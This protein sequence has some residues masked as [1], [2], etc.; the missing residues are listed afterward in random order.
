MKKVLK[1][2]T[3]SFFHAF[4]GIYWAFTTQPNFIIHGIL[5]FLA[6]SLGLYF[7]ISR[8]EM[9]IIIFTII[10]GFTVE[11]INTSIESITDMVTAERRTEAKIAKDVSAGMML[12]TAIGAVII[13]WIIFGPYIQYL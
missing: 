1:R 8:I 11:M 7:H 10:L 5:S 3:V 2:H 9:L 13:A 12:L 4:E 6:I